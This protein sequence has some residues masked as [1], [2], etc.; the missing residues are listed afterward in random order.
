MNLTGG[1]PIT[2]V[3]LDNYTRA[4]GDE[5]FRAVAEFELTPAIEFETMAARLE[6]LAEEMAIDIELDVD[7]DGEQGEDQDDE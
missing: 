7:P 2:A 6:A 3:G 4:V 5:L 1:N